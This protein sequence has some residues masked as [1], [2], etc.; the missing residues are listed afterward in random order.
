M[1]ER[2]RELIRACRATDL[3]RVESLLDAGAQIEVRE[4]DRNFTPLLS[5]C[6]AGYQNAA[7][8]PVIRLLLERGAQPNCS[9]A[10]DD[11]PLHYA[12]MFGHTEAVRLLLQ[13]GAEVDVH[14]SYGRTPLI[15]AACSGQPEMVELLLDAGA[16]LGAVAEGGEDALIDMTTRA[17]ASPEVAR[18]LIERGIDYRSARLTQGTPLSWASFCGRAAIVEVLLD[19]GVPVDEP[20]A[21]GELSIVRAMRQDRREVV[22]LLLARGADPDASSLYGYSLLEYATEKGDDELLA[23]VLRRRGSRATPESGEALLAAARKGDVARLTR[24]LEHGLHLDARA[25][26]SGETALMKAA[27]YGQGEVV[28]FLLERGAA[29][30][31]ED[32]RGNTALLHAAYMGRSEIVGRLLEAGAALEHRNQLNWTALMQAC[33]EGHLAA[34][35]VLLEAGATSDAI[36]AERGATALS[37]ARRSGCRQLVERLLAH[38]ACDRPIRERDPADAS[39]SIFD[40]DVCAYWPQRMELGRTLAADPTEELLVVHSVTDYP[41][42]YTSATSMLKRCR[43][44]D[45]YYLHEHSV[46]DEDAFIAGPTIRQTIERLT[47]T[48]ARRLLSE[49]GL[50]DESARLAATQTQQTAALA[51]AIEAGRPL[52]AKVL[53][54]AIEV[55]VDAGVAAADWDAIEGRLLAD[56]RPEVALGALVDLLVIAA[57][58]PYDG[59]YVQ[60]RRFTAEQKSRTVAL[61]E[62]RRDAL[63]SCLQR[64]AEEGPTESLYRSARERLLPTER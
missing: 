7:C 38:G 26:F 2:D 33:I 46:D 40:C 48:R 4:P 51:A 50:E 63:I 56:P 31:A 43:V 54:Y 29:V 6:E 47:P 3:G 45:A 53:P 30:D 58:Q 52:G 27:Y 10:G 25:S 12:A 13:A 24:L 37:L 44:C 20:G 21:D 55:L 57:E 1:D 64:F 18:L 8:I 59:P 42:R 60:R 49:R 5:A 39:F 23:D 15:Y 32:S 17:D 28:S 62:G 34:A 61:L 11:G 19:A 36:D 14:G 16:D 9:A 35:V 41:D 22:R